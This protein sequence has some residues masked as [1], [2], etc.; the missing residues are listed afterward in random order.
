MAS[1]RTHISMMVH[2]RKVSNVCSLILK[3][4]R[5][6]GVRNRGGDGGRAASADLHTEGKEGGT[7][8]SLM[9]QLVAVRVTELRTMSDAVPDVGQNML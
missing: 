7:C 9:F 1:R 6:G 3:T 2:N 4:E 5:D 8:F